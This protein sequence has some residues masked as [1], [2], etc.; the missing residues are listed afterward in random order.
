MDRDTL[1]HHSQDRHI[2]ELLKDVFFTLC[3]LSLFSCCLLLLSLVQVLSSRSNLLES[4]R[5]LFSRLSL[6]VFYQSLLSPV[7]VC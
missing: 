1:A 6:L 4:H 2:Q 3:A 7:R 5:V